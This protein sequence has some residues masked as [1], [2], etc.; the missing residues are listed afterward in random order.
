M[1][2][3]N[4]EKLFQEY[5]DTGHDENKAIEFYID[6]LADKSTDQSV[7]VSAYRTN[8]TDYARLTDRQAARIAELERDNA[9]L[10]ADLIAARI[11][12]EMKDNQIKD[13]TAMIRLLR[14]ENAYLKTAADYVPAA[15]SV[16]II[17]KVGAAL[18]GEKR[19]IG[20]KQYGPLVERARVLRDRCAK[21]VKALEWY[22]QPGEFF[23]DAVKDYTNGGSTLSVFFDDNGERAREALRDGENE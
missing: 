13:Q 8:I 21:M 11:A 10:R 9:A 17:D 22:A 12:A 6:W 18:R 19:S 20:I 15:Q 1:M 23:V 3:E 14:E 4:A 7:V 5:K 16:D 2:S